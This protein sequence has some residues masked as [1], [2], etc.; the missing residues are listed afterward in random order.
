MATYQVGYLIGS[1][2]ASSINRK[3]ARCLV[4]L[5]PAELALTEIPIRDL[6]LYDHDLDDNYPPAGRAI[7]EAVE[8]ADAL[9]FVTPEYNRSFPGGLKNAIDWASRPWGQNSF[10]G[11]PTAIIGAS[12]GAIG[13]ACAQQHLRNVLGYCDVRQMNQP[14]AYIHFKPEVFAEDGSVTDPSTEE[15]LRGFMRSFASFVDQAADR[16]R[17]RSA[18]SH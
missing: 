2:A 18:A 6:P 8:S 3:L 7:K 1:V 11:K 17:Q 13:T 4:R 15:F 16:S 5:A 10:A 12:V 14:E 9:L